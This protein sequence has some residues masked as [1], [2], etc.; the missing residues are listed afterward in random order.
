MRMFPSRFVL[1]LPIVL[2][3][4]CVAS[5][6]P[7]AST[8]VIEADQLQDAIGAKLD[9]TSADREAIQSLLARP[10]VSA[11]ASGAG[12]DLKRAQNAV[13]TLSGPE[14]SSLAAQARRAD[15]QLAGEGDVS[16]STTAII[17]G[18]LVVILLVLIL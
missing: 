2:L 9:Q 5:A 12:L 11:I 14:L 15:A 18:L 10:Q 8:H 3:V 13:N 7:N 16:I 6:A 1:I 4:P 17:I